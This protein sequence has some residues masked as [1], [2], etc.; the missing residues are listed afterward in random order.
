MA[1]ARLVP[2]V[3]VTAPEGVIVPLAP[4]EAVMVKVTGGAVAKEAAMV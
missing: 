3:T 2:L 1:K 4:A